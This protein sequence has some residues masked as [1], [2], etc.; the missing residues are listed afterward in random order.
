MWC[1]A[2]CL[3][4]HL[5]WCPKCVPEVSRRCPTT[6]PQLSRCV[7]VENEK[8]TQIVRMK[9]V[10]GLREE[11]RADDDVGYSSIL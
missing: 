1:L 4:R 3:E 8:K 7:L 6:V 11:G 10:L 5:W 2:V 9:E